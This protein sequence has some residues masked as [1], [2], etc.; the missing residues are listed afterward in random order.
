MFTN[1][2]LNQEIQINY[3]FHNHIVEKNIV[4]KLLFS[5][6]GNKIISLFAYK[7]FNLSYHQLSLDVVFILFIRDTGNWADGF[8]QRNIQ[9]LT[10]RQLLINSSFVKIFFNNLQLVTSYRVNNT[11]Y[12]KSMQVIIHFISFVKLYE[13]YSVSKWYIYWEAMQFWWSWHIKTHDSC[14]DWRLYGFFYFN[15]MHQT[16]RKSIM[17]KYN[18][19]PFHVVFFY[20]CIIETN[21]VLFFGSDINI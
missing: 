2:K 10:R 8:P 21:T 3:E 19:S 18:R 5:K 17:N 13:F 20:N 14:Q 9:L 11:T 15:K 6:N 16:N 12:T 7:Q 4:L 1:A